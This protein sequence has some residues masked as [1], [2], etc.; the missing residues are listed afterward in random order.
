MSPALGIF[1]GYARTSFD[2]TGS[3]A[4]QPAGINL[5]AHAITER[6]TSWKVGMNGGL[7]VTWQPWSPI[8]LTLAGRGGVFWTSTRL[9]ASDCFAAVGGF[10]ECT[11][12][13]GTAP[14]PFFATSAEDRR[15]AFGFVG[16]I[17]GALSYDAGWSVLS[18]GGFFTWESAVAGVR[19]PVNTVGNGAG[20][21]QIAD[22]ASIRFNSGWKAG[23]FVTVRILLN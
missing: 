15:S 11:T 16:S 18:I 19:N 13:P 23:G 20:G 2:F 12:P 5:I 7:A 9:S 8:T 21:T 10:T 3:W 1:G 22:P 17:Q 6:L 14:G 4:V